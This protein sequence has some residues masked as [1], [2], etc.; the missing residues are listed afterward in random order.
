MYM[1]TALDG[2]PNF[3]VIFGPNTVTGHSSVI[4]A[5]ENMVN[6]AIKF[7]KPILTGDVIQTEVKKEAELRWASTIQRDLKKTVWNKGGCVSWYKGDDGWNSTAYPY[8]QIYFT[9]R[10]MFPKYSDWDV[11]YTSKGLA[12]RKVKSILKYLTYILAIGG[13]YRAKKNGYKL[14]DILALIKGY[15]RAAMMVA[16]GSL[17]G[18]AAKI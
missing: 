7:I 18:V 15:L 10:C 12:K 2:F 13:L 9:L 8:T 11:T 1:G 4:L 14:K 16:A 5:S 17:Q 3:F 6:L